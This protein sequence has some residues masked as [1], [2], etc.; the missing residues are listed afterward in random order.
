MAVPDPEADL[1]VLVATL[2][3]RVLGTNLFR[4]SELAQ[5]GGVPADCVFVQAFPGDRPQPL[6]GSGKDVKSADV[7]ITVRG[8]PSDRETAR[9]T[10]RALMAGVQRAAPSGLPDYSLALLVESEPA[11]EDYDSSQCHYYGFSLTL[12]WVA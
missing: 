4:G 12:Q 2:T 11:Y 8:P 3:S 5:D 6:L 7:K 1:A 9:T 10:A